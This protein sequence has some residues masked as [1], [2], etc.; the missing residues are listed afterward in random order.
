MEEKIKE[1]D[2][3][4]YSIIKKL[5]VMNPEIEKQIYQTI[6]DLKLEEKLK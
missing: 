1:T 3:I 2:E 6:K 4:T 5:I